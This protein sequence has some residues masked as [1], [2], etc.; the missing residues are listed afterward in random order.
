VPYGPPLNTANTQ[1]ALSWVL[2]ADGRQCPQQAPSLRPWSKPVVLA[3]RLAGRHAEIVFV[4]DDLA[5]WLIFISAEGGRKKLTSLILGD[6]QERALRPAATEA[7]QLTSAELCP[8]DAQR[9]EELAIMVGQLFKTPVPGAP[10]TGHETLLEALQEGI[11]GQLKLLDNPRLTVTVKSLTGMGD[12]SATIVA[13]KLTGHLMREIVARGSRGGPLAPLA[14]QLSDDRTY[15]HGL[16]MEGKVDQLDDKLLEVLALLGGT[17]AVAAAPVALVQLPAVTA[18]FTGRD[19]ELAVLAGLLDPAGSSG[20]VVVSA[21]AGLAGVGKTTLAV[22]AGHVARRQSWFGGGVLFI[23]LHG[24]D[25]APVQPEQALDAL[26]RA[27]GAVAEHIPPGVEERAALYRSALGRITEPVLVIADNASSEAQ[28]RPLLPGPG[29]HKVV[30]T[31]RHTLGGLEARLL[32]VTIL[33]DTA[34]VDLMDKALRQ[35]RP[36]DDRIGGNLQGAARLARLCGGLPLALQ[37]TAALLKADPELSTAELTDQLSGEKDRLAG[38]RYDDGNGTSGPSVAATF[39]L[40]YHRLDEAAARMFRLLPVSSGPDVSTAVAAKL[41]DLPFGRA[42]GVLG[43]LSKAHLIEVA[44]G[45]KGRWRMHDLLRLYAQQLSDRH[46]KADDREGGRDRLLHYYLNAAT[47]AYQLLREVY[48]AGGNVWHDS[49]WEVYQRLGFMD[50]L[51]AAAWLLPEA[52][53]DRRRARYK[54]VRKEY[55]Q[56]GQKTD[57]LDATYHLLQ[58]ASAE[59]STTPYGSLRKDYEQFG[60]STD[61]L[62]RAYHLLREACANKGSIRYWLGWREDVWS[63]LSTDAL[64]TAYRHLRPAGDKDGA[65]FFT[66][67]AEARAW[68][69]DERISLAAAIEMAEDTGRGRIASRLAALLAEYF[70]SERQF[71][72]WITI[73][74]MSRPVSSRGGHAR[75]GDELHDTLQD[76][77]RLDKAITDLQEAV[78]IFQNNGDQYGE[79]MALNN[80]G[81]A[82]RKARRFDEAITALHRA[83]VLYQGGDDRYGH[84]TALNNLGSTLREARRFEEAISALQEAAAI[85]RGDQYRERIVLLNLERTYAA[86]KA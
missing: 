85:F 80:L 77:R 51:D 27:L 17:R 7:V 61:A 70:N 28:V 44:P 69:D 41:A 37:I 56:Y 73:T 36:N 72:D 59:Q 9:A 29:P 32:D 60:L 58:E 2:C 18:G 20:P 15:L 6:D 64:Y 86:Q 65:G 63:V 33:D 30:I 22:E 74:A 68:F 1:S 53:G 11:A 40:S 26:L 13:Q 47:V 79:A 83:V 52:S 34:G 50:V 10:L 19:D 54:S 71:D 62:D 67:S 48:D 31:S 24:Y 76:L 42:R 23:D 21:V 14:H 78:T 38:L 4:A 5:A 55:Q 81:L 12:L 25:E 3:E 57:A 43:T 82:L 39:G 84:G 75:K 49:P 8:G 45:P 16:Q 35:A 66:S 46:A